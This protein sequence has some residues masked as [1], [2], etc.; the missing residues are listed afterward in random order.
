MN[1][2]PPIIS[3]TPQDG[4]DADR[5]HRQLERDFSQSPTGSSG[6]AATRA[7]PTASRSPAPPGRPIWRRARD[8]GRTLRVVVTAT[9]LR[10]LGGRDLRRDDGRAGD[11]RPSLGLWRSGTWTKPPAPSCTTRSETTLALSTQ[12]KPGFRLPWGRLRRQRLI[13]LRLGPTAGDLNPGSADITIT[14]HFKT[15]GTPCAPGGLGSDSQGPL[16]HYRR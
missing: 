7:V 15:T 3:G 16:H 2:S 5:E 10:R 12:S 11:S 1:T 14:I 9:Q 6:S 13:Q 8:V 4:A